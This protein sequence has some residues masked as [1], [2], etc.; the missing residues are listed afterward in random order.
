MAIAYQAGIPIITVSSFGG[1]GKELSNRYLDD[2]KRLKCI[3][4]STP[5]EALQKALEQVKNR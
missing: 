4:A 2:R 5:E 3:Q 1:W